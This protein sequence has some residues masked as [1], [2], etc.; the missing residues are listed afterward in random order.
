MTRELWHRTIFLY[1]ERK[2]GDAVKWAV[3]AR[4]LLEDTPVQS[5]AHIQADA[6]EENGDHLFNFL[7]WRFE[8]DVDDQGEMSS[9]LG[10]AVKELADSIRKEG[11]V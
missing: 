2:G 6:I 8:W 7:S 10:G 3:S 11:G 4:E 1:K 9:K 5:L